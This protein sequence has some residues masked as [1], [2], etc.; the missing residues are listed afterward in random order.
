[1]KTFNHTEKYVLERCDYILKLP[2][3]IIIDTIYDAE[4]T[5]E[6]GD[7]W[8]MEKYITQLKNHLSSVVLKKGNYN[9]T[10][11]YS[12]GMKSQG[13]QYVKKFGI[14]SMQKDIRGFLCGELFNDYDIINAHPTILLYVRDK[15]F[16][17]QKLPF[18]EKYIKDREDI[19]KK[20]NIT[21]KQILIA[22]NMGQTIKSDN[23][24][25]LGIDREFKQMQNLIFNSTHD[26][27]IEV[28][29][30]GLKKENKKGCFLNRV[31]CVFEN[32]IL[33][34]AMELFNSKDIGSAM[35]DGFFLNSEL[36]PSEV[37]DKLNNQMTEYGIKWD[38]KE[39]SDKIKIDNSLDLPEYEDDYTIQKKEFEENHLM[40]ENPLLFIKQ[41]DD[42][43]YGEYCKSS[44]LSLTEDIRI[45]VD[46]QDVAFFYEWLKDKNKRKYQK[47]VFDPVLNNDK[48]W[49]LYTGFEFD[50]ILPKN[51][52]EGVDEFIS[53]LNY[54]C[55]DDEASFEYLLNY[56]CHIFQ[57]P[58]DRPDVAILLNGAKGTGKD[59]I[60]SFIENILGNKY[61][62]RVQDL[63]TVFGNFNSSLKNK[64]VLQINEL[65]G[66]NGYKHEQ[67]L[68]NL[69]T[70]DTTL[71]NEKMVKPYTIE[72][73]IRLFMCSNSDNPLKLTLDNRRYFVIETPKQKKDISYYTR[74]RQMLKDKK[75]LNSI[76]S[77]CM[78]RDIE[79]FNPRIFPVTNRMKALM[80]NSVDPI[81]YFIQDCIDEDMTIS[82]QDLIIK[83][84]HYCNT[85]GHSTEHVNARN[86]K[87]KM[88]IIGGT[89]VCYNRYRGYDGK[90]MRGFKINNKLLQQE[91]NNYLKSVED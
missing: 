79:E 8:D 83:Y 10:Y 32:E 47:I 14:Q 42:D 90:Q 61:V 49:N 13:R 51:E 3:E 18:L 2:N 73:Y 75:I 58:A 80:Q 55:S 40:I 37:I 33:K 9:Q 35:F 44:F 65:D 16:K 68:K 69:I 72:N 56:I 31:L 21:K 60:I 1:M 7:K 87:S 27:F 76:Y 11:K 25:L 5:N 57:K 63:E 6:N 41:F 17:N 4:E 70:A 52:W 45:T 82:G 30:T 38:M 81:Y 48:Y 74:M 62:S 22:M 91:V 88:L 24:F 19:L 29:K 39:H 26:K 67:A 23:N 20:W 66:K 89:A 85:N 46:G 12:K 53:H 28:P 77:Y 50:N 43:S 64:L 15:Y 54:M 84:K 86:L 78:K 34:E 59:I 36:E 71:I